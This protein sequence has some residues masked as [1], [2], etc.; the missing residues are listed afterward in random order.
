[1]S[2]NIKR[3]TTADGPFA[4]IAGGVSETRCPDNNVKDG[5]TYFY[6]ISAVNQGVEGVDS[7]AVS[8]A[9]SSGPLPDAWKQA[10]VGSVRKAGSASHIAATGMFTVS[11]AG[12]DIWD[13]EGLHFVYQPL[14]GDG[15]LCARVVSYD[16]THDW[17]KV[18]VMIRGALDGKPAMA[19][20]AVT[21]GKGCG[22]SF[23]SEANGKCSMHGGNPQPWVKIERRGETVVG[24]VSPD[25][26]A[27][28]EFGQAKVAL[29]KDAFIGLAVCSHD[30]NRLDKA[31]FDNV[32]LSGGK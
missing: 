3:A 24:L 12:D 27:W 21:P 13:V 23:R 7:E 9:P 11:G 10:A 6:K 28:T 17:A 2:Y 22:M 32:V 29:G 4:L 1:M 19:V 26:K 25:G 30:G 5:T 8:A 18:G 14:S 15:A 20:M 16:D 31:L